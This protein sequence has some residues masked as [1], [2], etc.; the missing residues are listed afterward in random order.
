MIISTGMA[1][2]EEIGEALETAKSSGCD[3]IALL[4]CVSGYPAPYR[5]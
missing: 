5:L 2:F 3:E 1:N 4:H